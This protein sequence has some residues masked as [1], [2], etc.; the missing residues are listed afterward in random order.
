MKLTRLLFFNDHYQRFLGEG[1]CPCER[2]CIARDIGLLNDARCL[3]SD[4]RD[5]ATLGLYQDTPGLVASARA[6]VQRLD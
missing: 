1:G 4:A 3:L 6:V 5:Y 2:V